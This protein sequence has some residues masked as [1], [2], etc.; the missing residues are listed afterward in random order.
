MDANRIIFRHNHNHAQG[1]TV[2]GAGG[3]RTYFVDTDTM[4]LHP[5]VGR[6]KRVSADPGV[7]DPDDIAEFRAFPGTFCEVVPGFESA[8]DATQPPP[9]P[10]APPPPPG[11]DAPPPGPDA[12]LG[13]SVAK[14]GAALAAGEADHLDLRALADQERAGQDRVGALK[15][16]LARFQFLAQPD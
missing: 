16:I 10:D 14:L 12:L 5:I 4:L 9:G 3:G 8:S 11:P 15:A 2:S 7:S 1:Q 6:Q 13:L